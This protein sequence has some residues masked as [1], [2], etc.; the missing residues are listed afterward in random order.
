[1]ACA[2][3]SVLRDLSRQAVEI[4]ESEEH[5]WRRRLWMDF[6]ALRPVRTPVSVA[7]YDSVWER[8]IARPGDIVCPEGLARHIEVR[9]RAAIWKARNIA[10]DEPLLAEV[11]LWTPRPAGRSLLWGLPLESRRAGRYGSYK[12]VPPVTTEADLERMTAPVY[13]EDANE[14]QLLREQA[15][16]LTGGL[17]SIR[18]RTDELHYGPFEWAVRLRGMDNLLLD[19]VDSPGL[20]HRLMEKVTAGM[21]SYHLQREAAGA[22][23]AR[24]AWAVHILCDEVPSGLEARLEG[25][26]AYVHAQSAASLSPGMYA[27]FIQPYNERIARLF[28]RVYYHGCEDLSAKAAIIRRLPNLRLF[29]VSP[30]TPVGPVVEALGNGVALEVHSHPV[31]VLFTDAPEDSRADVERL[32]REAGGVPHILKLCDVESVPDG[33]ARLSLWA[34]LAREVAESNA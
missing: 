11:W 9:L 14:K 29:H 7:L 27:D 34:R 6:H 16:E 1:M 4:A 25:S 10:D 24:E 12:P 2:A 32:H 22:V 18:F 31:R 21:V 23:D 19:V 30:W 8:D 13:E 26:W 17:L 33:G 3:A 15:L 28:G 20:V 5:L